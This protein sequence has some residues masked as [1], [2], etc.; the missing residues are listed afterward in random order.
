VGDVD[1]DLKMLSFRAVKG[2]DAAVGVDVD[3]RP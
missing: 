1:K 2:N 3:K